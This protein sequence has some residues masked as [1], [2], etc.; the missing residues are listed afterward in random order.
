[1]RCHGQVP[2]VAGCATTRS[3]Y[4]VLAASAAF[5]AAQFHGNRVSSSRRLV[6][7]ETIRSSTSVS[8]ANGSRPFN[9][10]LYAA[11]R[12]MPN[13]SGMTMVIE[14]LSAVA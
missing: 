5:S 12:T 10:A 8:Q 14:A 2:D 4:A 3:P 11:R 13:G 1:M 6:R 7:P 9:F